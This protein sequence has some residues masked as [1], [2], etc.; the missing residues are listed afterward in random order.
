MLI[1][2]S[3]LSEAPRAPAAGGAHS[4]AGS[5]E[6]LLHVFVVPPVMTLPADHHEAPDC[7]LADTA[8]EEGLRA[9]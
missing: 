5:E 4:L 6:P 3:L 9:I 1:I 8:E 7:L 2:K